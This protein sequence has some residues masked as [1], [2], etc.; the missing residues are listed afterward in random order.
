[1]KVGVKLIVGGIAGIVAGGVMLSM[2]AEKPVEGMQPMPAWQ[3]IAVIVLGV[4]L[5]V[6]GGRYLMTDGRDQG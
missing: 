4:G 2:S 5:L 1:M 3:G 6:A